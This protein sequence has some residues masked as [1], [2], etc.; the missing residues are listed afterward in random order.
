MEG[1]LGNVVGTATTL[2]GACEGISKAI[3][4]DAEFVLNLKKSLN[5]AEVDGK[6]DRGEELANLTL[7]YRHLEDAR[8]R[9]G[10]VIQA[11]AGGKSIY[12]K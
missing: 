7:A 8:M 12:D 11:H 1:Q 2:E 6:E 5:E 10:K 4:M 3:Q 9:L